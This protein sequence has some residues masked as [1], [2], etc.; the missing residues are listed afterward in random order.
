MPAHHCL[1]V[2]SERTF[3]DADFCR[4]CV[5]DNGVGAC[6]QCSEDGCDKAFHVTCGLQKKFVSFFLSV[7]FFFEN[8]DFRFCSVKIIQKFLIFDLFL[9]NQ[10]YYKIYFLFVYLL[11]LFIFLNY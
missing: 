10:C 3:S 1:F 9:V 11:C 6:L 7:F 5:C 2:V 4:C 8:F